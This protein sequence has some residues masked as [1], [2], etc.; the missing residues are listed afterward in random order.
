MQTDVDRAYLAGAI[1]GGASFLAVPSKRAGPRIY[2]QVPGPLIK[3]DILARALAPYGNRPQTITM[4]GGKSYF[5]RYESRIVYRICKVSRPS[6]DSAP[7]S[8]RGDRV[9]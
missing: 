4:R 9:L 6:C 1:D 5:L 3:L 7:L 2:L 8:H